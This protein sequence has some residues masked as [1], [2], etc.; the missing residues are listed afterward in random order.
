[1]DIHRVS[2]IQYSVRCV[3]MF[4]L[5]A[6]SFVLASG[7]IQQQQQQQQQQ[8]HG[9]VST[10]QHSQGI[11]Y[12]PYTAYTPKR[13]NT[14]ATETQH[15]SKQRKLFVSKEYI[16]SR[17]QWD[18]NYRN[19]TCCNNIDCP[20]AICDG[21]CGE[22]TIQ[23]VLLYYGSYVS[24]GL[25]RRTV[26]FNDHH[27]A[28][29]ILIDTDQPYRKPDLLQTALK[30]GLD[31]DKWYAPLSGTNGM[32]QFLNW[33]STF[34]K[35]QDTPVAIGVTYYN[36]YPY[37][38]DHIVTAVESFSTGLRFNDHYLNKTSTIVT[39]SL[40]Y[41]G[42]RCKYTYCFG[43]YMYGVALKKPLAF[44]KEFLVRLKIMNSDN[45]R[46]PNW[47]CGR[48]KYKTLSL[49]AT[50]AYPELLDDNK[51]WFVAVVFR[52]S[53]KAGDIRSGDLFYGSP[54]ECYELTSVNDSVSIQVH[55]NKA[56]YTRI[57]PDGK[58]C[59]L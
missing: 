43:T 45:F 48:I 16:P 40:P 27:G 55:S 32:I 46:E 49:Q 34:L 28:L 51:T 33:T 5:V 57:V 52:G 8:Q 36:S 17:R 35:Q 54:I 14:H 9:N 2:S 31:V 21:Y 38:Y 30:L 59:P 53:S 12:S 20:K 41:P 44:D 47:T 37:S 26:Q 42:R 39:K 56:V 3:W 19:L 1:M 50:A 24:Q 58:G 4:L 22:T 18:C 15:Y 10:E 7:N 25:I 23:E 6:P 11:F 13:I 29:E